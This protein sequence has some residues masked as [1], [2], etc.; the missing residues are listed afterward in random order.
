[1]LLRQSWEDQLLIILSVVQ[2]QRRE[3][4]NWPGLFPGLCVSNKILRRPDP[5]DLLNSSGC[6]SCSEI[7]HPPPKQ[8][9]RA[10]LSRFICSDHSGSDIAFGVAESQLKMAVRKTDPED[11]LPISWTAWTAS[12]S[13]SVC[14]WCRSVYAFS[15]S[16]NRVNGR[17]HATHSYLTPGFQDRPVNMYFVAGKGKKK[18][19]LLN[20]PRREWS[21]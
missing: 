14:S 13:V 3:P 15:E 8:F 6:L 19:P 2:H 21:Q 20:L 1:M 7:N 5:A 9:P 10:L 11:G 17:L 18:K 12:E 16:S 4:P